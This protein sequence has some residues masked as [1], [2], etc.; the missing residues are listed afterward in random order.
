MTSSESRFPFQFERRYAIAGR[1]FGVTEARTAI[2]V[3]DSHLHARFGPW[4]IDT[5]LTNL[6]R[7][8]LTGPYA[9]LKTAGPAHLG[10]TDRGLTFAT[11]SHAGVCMEFAEPITGIDPFG[12]IRHP[13]L[14]LTPGDCAGLAAALD[15]NGTR[16]GSAGQP[17]T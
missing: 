14:T 8:S 3:T 11:N 7:V 10:L 16:S 4:R 15:R 17:T 9:F 13:N 6:T 1:L 5:A 12:Q 2:V